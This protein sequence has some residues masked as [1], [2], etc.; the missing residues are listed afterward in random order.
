MF[1]GHIPY[2]HIPPLLSA[3]VM[4][5]IMRGMLPTPPT[6]ST[7]SM[8][9]L[10][11]Y[12][13]NLCSDCWITNPDIRPDVETIVMDL[14][15]MGEHS[16]VEGIIIQTVDVDDHLE[17]SLGTVLIDFKILDI[18]T[19]ICTEQMKLFASGGFADIFETYFRGSADGT[20][21][22]AI[23]PL[24]VKIYRKF[25]VSRITTNQRQKV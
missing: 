19:S 15:R 12:L 11:T 21:V 23:C 4:V 22:H 5:E 18:T 16:T 14:I 3:I 24:A 7:F 20:Q 25:Y 1:T 6:S 17:S 9:S 8:S 13:W 10:H 2:A